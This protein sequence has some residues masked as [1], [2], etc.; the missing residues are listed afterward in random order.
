MKQKNLNRNYMKYIESFS[1]IRITNIAEVGGKNASI[2]QMIH[3]LTKESILIPDGFAT[4]STAYWYFIDSNNLRSEIKK[5]MQTITD[6][7]KTEQLT[8]A[9]KKIRKL[10]ES[11]PIPKDL[12]QEIKTAYTLLCKTK[13][14]PVAV[15]SSATAEDL[16]TAS[17][18]GQQETFLNVRGEK[19]LLNSWR[20]CVSSLFTPRAIIYRIVKNFDYEKIALSVGIQQMIEAQRAGVSF[21]LDTETGFK[22]VV[23]ITSAYGL[24]ENIVKGAVNPDEFCVHKPTLLEGY[25]PILSKKIGTKKIAAH[26]AKK[27]IKNIRVPKI[28]QEQFSL[29]NNEILEI[30]RQSI[31]IENLYTKKN[32][33]WTPMD[34]EWAIGKDNKLYIVQARPE[35]VHAHKKYNTLTEYKLNISQKDLHKKLI[36]TGQSVGQQV[37]TGTARIVTSVR[38]SHKVQHGDI[39]VTTMTDPDWVPIMK[40][41]AAIITDRGG[42]TCHSAIVS[43]ELGVPAIVG[44]KNATKKIKNGEK[45]TIDC[46]QG[47]TGYIYKGIIPF[48]KKEINLKKLPKAPVD[49][50]LNISQP[51][52]AFALSFLPVKGVGLARLEF[53]ISNNIQIHPLALLNLKDVTNKKIKKEIQERVAAYKNPADYFVDILA[54]DVATI[55]AAFWPNPVTVRLSDFKSNEY[56]NLI[57]GQFFEPHEENPMLGLRGASRYYS[58]LYKDAFALECK[59][60]KQARDVKGFKNIKIMVPFV[61]T[62]EEARKSIALMKKHGLIRG[63]D[64]L[65][66]VMMCEVPS[67]VLLI[68][69]FS[70]YFDGFSIGSNDLTQLTLGVDR[71]AESLAQLFDERNEAVKKFIAMA[72]TGAHKNK[73]YIGICGQAPSDYFE[74]GQW[75]IKEKIDSISLNPDAI[76]SFQLD[77]QHPVASGCNITGTSILLDR[78][79]PVASD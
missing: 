56:R 63:K 46:S 45:I 41:A 35:T 58:D 62:L 48:T 7:N 59:A 44:T 19:D 36:T 30:A 31:V 66:F 40:K 22:D 72:I 50:L 1:K 49:I 53:I 60:L 65:E 9:S 23:F 74:F 13:N 16:P 70:K 32:K 69:E 78:Q 5:L 43:R 64:D 26:Y 12:A 27:G 76:T 25:K 68:D 38:D 14:C 39:L 15:R 28:K 42:R 24:G 10:L 75:L 57:G 79:H 6:I 29:T 4:T 34:I 61:R 52:Q 18:A 47:E 55:A 11:K 17:F 2:G 20:K 51:N 67:N 71:D 54:Q 73:K 21:T 3:D 37:A 77:R 8:S 33:R